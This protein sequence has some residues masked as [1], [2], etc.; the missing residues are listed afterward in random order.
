MSVVII[1]RD[2]GGQ[3]PINDCEQI[4]HSDDK[5]LADISA[6]QKAEHPDD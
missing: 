3:V 5:A 4:E 2:H 1:G 6:E